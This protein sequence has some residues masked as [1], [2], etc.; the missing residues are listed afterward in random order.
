MSQKSRSLKNFGAYIKPLNPKRTVGFSWLK[1]I[2]YLGKKLGQNP[3]FWRWSLIYLNIHIT[4]RGDRRHKVHF[5]CQQTTTK[6]SKWSQK[7]RQE[8]Y[9]QG[10][11]YNPMITLKHV[12]AFLH[13]YDFIR[14]IHD[15]RVIW[16]IRQCW[17]SWLKHHGIQLNDEDLHCGGTPII[18]SLILAEGL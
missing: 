11:S 12:L 13:R 9:S 14:E 17:C 18:F 7:T 10:T 16:C 6:K 3:W 1:C 2:W 4:W 15:S 5:Q 8:H